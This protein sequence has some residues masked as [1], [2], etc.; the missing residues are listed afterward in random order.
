MAA[1]A[2]SLGIPT[3]LIMATGSDSAPSLW[4]ACSSGRGREVRPGL[5]LDARTL[6]PATAAPADGGSDDRSNGHVTTLGFEMGQP[7]PRAAPKNGST[8]LTIVLAVAD[9][10]KPTLLD[11]PTTARTALAISPGVG[12]REDL[13]R[14][15]VAVDEAG[16]RI[17]GIVVADPDPSD[18][19]R[20]RR[21]LDDRS[22]R[23]FLPVRTTGM[24]DVR[25]SAV[26]PRH[27]R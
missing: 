14:L 27:R 11:V 20:G 23:V 16:R 24:A 5:H 13:A 12:T 9:A 1:F 3:R 15:A 18:G 8:Q 19:T 6:Q 21:P 25:V 2:A 4:A 17:D 22:R 26:E 10:R 7:K